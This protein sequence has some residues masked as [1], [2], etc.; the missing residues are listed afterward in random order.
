MLHACTYARGATTGERHD[1]TCW[2]AKKVYAQHDDI[3]L[4]NIDNG[5]FTE[6]VGLV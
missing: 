3:A 4:L 1:G 2:V 6:T 5:N